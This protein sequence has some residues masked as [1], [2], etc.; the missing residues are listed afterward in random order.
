MTDTLIALTPATAGLAGPQTLLSSAP[1][2]A[3]AD[4]GRLVSLYQ[5]APLRVAATACAVGVVF[6]AEYNGTSR[7]YRVI[8]AGITA[9]ASMAGTTPDYDLNAPRDS[10]LSVKDG[11]C[12]LR[13]LGQGKSAWGFGTITAFTDTDEVTVDVNP[14]GPFASTAASTRWRMGEFSAA[15]GWP[16]AMTYHL[17][18]TWWAGSLVKPQTLWSSETGDFKKMSPGEPDG[19][20][21][22]TSAITITIDDDQVN[23]L[24]W[25]LSTDRGLAAGAESGEFLIAPAV[26]NAA[27]SPSNIRAKRASNRG[28]SADVPGIRAGS[29]LLFIQNG[30]RKLRAL[31]Y[32]YATDKFIT[33]E[34]SQL[35][36][37]IT[38]PGI[39]EAAYQARPDGVLWLVRSDGKLACV[40]YDAE[41]K[42]RAWSFHEFGGTDAR[43]ES[44][45]CVPSP[46]GE[47]DDVYVSIC[48][49]VG[50]VDMRSIEVIRR[51]FRADLDGDDG[52]FFVDCG[53]TY[54]GPPALTFSGL[55]F[56]EGETVWICADGSVR[57]NRV[58]TAGAVTISGNAARTV[59]I[60]LPYTSR[61]TPMRFEAGAAQGTAQGKPQ[62]IHQVALRLLETRG[63][64]V[65]RA[66]VAWEALTTRQEGDPIGQ[67]PPLF[68][69]DRR[70][71][72]PGGWSRDA[73]LTIEH[74][75]PLPCTILAVM[76]E[77]VTSG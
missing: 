29:D 49:T 77:L 73:D 39:V 41:Q 21:L 31:D 60:G 45:C 30:G 25:L 33:P 38:G 22:D 27:L 42:V 67:A 8:G 47:D 6:H 65:G 68:T 55:D 75:D 44:V 18:R 57:Q 72:F 12:L 9:A 13:Y 5:E 63:G 2:F 66:G 35:S 52:G 58:V 48:R 51:P 70:V 20:V 34:L 53:L 15:R 61:L 14:R 56:L 43:A 69:G 62:R 19:T 50:G 28:A 32:D 37:H 1:L 76:P 7:L 36:D 64:R 59:H 71:P 23:T 40:T 4:V 24:R 17:Q 16:R 3:A 46:D 10:G 74:A 54:S 26:A 11:T